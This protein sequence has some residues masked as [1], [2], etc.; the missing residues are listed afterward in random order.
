[1]D[2]F[3]RKPTICGA[4]ALIMD[5]HSGYHLFG[6]YFEKTKGRLTTGKGNLISQVDKLKGLGAKTKRQI[7]KEYRYSLLESSQEQDT[8]N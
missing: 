7:P 2:W 4:P 3:F 1:M 6:S 5:Y 8:E